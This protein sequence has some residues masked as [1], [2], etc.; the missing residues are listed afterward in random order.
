MCTLRH[1][2]RAETLSIF[3]F[4]KYTVNV[5]Q[6]AFKM[7]DQRWCLLHESLFTIDWFQLLHHELNLT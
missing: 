1:L 6:S 7:M 5:D 2:L 4:V 3:S